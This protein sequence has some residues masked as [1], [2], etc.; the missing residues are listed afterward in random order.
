MTFID[1]FQMFMTEFHRFFIEITDI[2]HVFLTVLN[3]FW[4]KFVWKFF[5][6]FPLLSQHSQ[7]FQYQFILNTHHYFHPPDYLISETKNNIQFLYICQ[8][9][10]VVKT[11]LEEFI[12]NILL[13]VSAIL[14][15]LWFVCRAVSSLYWP[16]NCDLWIS[17]TVC[18]T[19]QQSIDLKHPF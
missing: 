3:L 13:R 8:V 9:I 4:G 2:D 15:P 6:K 16:C 11:F 7:Y 5:Y 12:F 1:K 19:N 17:V 18:P 14:V 10:Q